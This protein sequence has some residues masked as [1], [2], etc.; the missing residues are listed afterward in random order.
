MSKGYAT[1]GQEPAAF[2]TWPVNVRLPGRKSESVALQRNQHT[3][4]C[5]RMQF[6]SSGRNLSVGSRNLL[7]FPAGGPL[8]WCC[9]MPFDLATSSLGAAFFK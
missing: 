5:G 8:V 1:P 7:G 9:S 2:R 4:P 3:G 6:Y